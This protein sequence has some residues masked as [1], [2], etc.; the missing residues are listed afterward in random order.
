MTELLTTFP[1]TMVSSGSGNSTPLRVLGLGSPKVAAYASIAPALGELGKITYRDEKSFPGAANCVD[2][3]RERAYDL[4]LMPNPYGNER[5][6]EIYRGQRHAPKSISALIM[7]RSFSVVWQSYLHRLACQ[8][9]AA[10][11]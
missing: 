8:S 4:V 7:S 3:V 9:A 11:H 6:L 10:R 2:F 5:R 1:A